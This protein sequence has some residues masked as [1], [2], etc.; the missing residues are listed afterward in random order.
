MDKV[1]EEETINGD[2]IGI[3]L[4]LLNKLVSLLKYYLNKYVSVT[5]TKGDDFISCKF[6]DSMDAWSN[7]KINSDIRGIIN[8]IYMLNDSNFELIKREFDGRGIFVE[9]DNKFRTITFKN[10]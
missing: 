5:K 8:R 1:S 9:R 7:E 6:R 2:I 10:K 4:N 3:E